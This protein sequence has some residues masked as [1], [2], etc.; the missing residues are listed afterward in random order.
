MKKTLLAGLCV[1]VAAIAFAN[2]VSDS[3]AL[4]AQQCKISAETVAT[5][6]NLQ[7]GNTAI[8][9]DVASLISATLKVQENRDDAQKAMNRM[10]DDKAKDAST[11]EMKY[12][13]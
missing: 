7:Y 4:M 8:R 2:T 1:S 3:S 11:L 5:L 10:V 9:K 13:S 6:K 12:C